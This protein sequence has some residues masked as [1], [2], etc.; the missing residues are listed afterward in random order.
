MTDS[1]AEIA[2][3]TVRH[4]CIVFPDETWAASLQEN[5]YAYPRLDARE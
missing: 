3:M 5:L 4:A 2:W 1:F